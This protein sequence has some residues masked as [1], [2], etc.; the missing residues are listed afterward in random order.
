MP[1]ADTLF[2][3]SSAAMAPDGGW[4]F[5][6]N[7]NADLRYND[8]TLLVMNVGED[9]TVATD[10]GPVTLRGAASDRAR[11]SDW[12][13][14]PQPDY[15]H[16]LPRSTPPTCCW[17]AL[18]SNILNCDERL[19]VQAE[20]T[21]RIGSFAAGMVWQ[22]NCKSPCDV[23]CTADPDGARIILGVRG[24]TS[25][26]WVD[27]L[28]AGDGPHPALR[29][30]Q[31][32]ADGSLAECT[33]KVT[34]T[35]SV[36]F[37][38]SGDPNAPP[39]GLP[40]EP[41]ALALDQARGLLYV[42]HLVGNTSV[43]ASGGLSL[44][45]VSETALPSVA[46]FP[47]APK[48]VAPFNSPFAP[49]GAGNFGVTAL[50]LHAPLGSSPDGVQEIFVSSRYVPQVTTMI[51]FLSGNADSAT[52]NCSPGSDVVLLGGSDAL[53]SGLVGSEMRGVA[54]IDPPKSAPDQPQRA[55][56]LQ[57][58]PP[59]LVSFDVDRNSAGALTARPSAALETCSS[60]TF[61]YQQGTRLYV[62]C[63]DTGEIYVFD[64]TIPSIVTSFQVGRGPGGMV[65][66]PKLPVAYVLDFTQNDIVVVDLAPG[67]PTEDHVIQRIGFPT[68]TPR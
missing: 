13:I 37:S 39:V 66:D 7:S 30:R 36:L 27:V 53:N 38:Q 63:F 50:S 55:F 5:V 54:I 35:T 21:V 65:F 4:L 34:D 32:G 61:L 25:L 45:D 64:A 3:P 20:T 18:D 19:Y 68:T 33:Q 29:C 52:W 24:D 60:P 6:A 2:F 16:P 23:G 8:G 15:V 26:T 62:N 22:P 44:F 9:R 43:V 1:P 46:G 56:V 10:S 11:P 40:D 57:R 58:V 17:D 41:Y 14:C 42:G 49:N 48:F 12:A 51:P 67:S 47:S 59:A 31:D 28:P